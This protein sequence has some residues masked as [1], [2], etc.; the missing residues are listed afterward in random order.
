MYDEE[1]K[2]CVNKLPDDGSSSIQ[3]Q[4]FRSIFAMLN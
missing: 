1:I 2:V 3:I 4:I